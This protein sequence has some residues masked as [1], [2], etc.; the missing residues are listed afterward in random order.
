[1]SNISVF[2]FES[3]AIR[4][5]LI[6]GE[7]W[8]VAADVCAVLEHSNTSKAVKQHCRGGRVLHPVQTAGGNQKVRVISEPDVLRLILGSNLAAG[9]NAAEFLLKSFSDISGVLKALSEFEVP[10]DLPDMYVYAIR[11]TVT[12]NVKLGI[13]RDPQTRL[14]QLQTGNDCKLELVATRKAENRFSDEVALHNKYSE[15]RIQGEWF[16]GQVSLS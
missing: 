14:K 16:S 4:S 7:P 15:L 2:N 1:M 3:K 5:V 9:V 11:N 6:E 13:S 10:D 8:F 12:G